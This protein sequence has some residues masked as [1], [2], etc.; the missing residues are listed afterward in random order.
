MILRIRTTAVA[1]LILYTLLAHIHAQAATVG[2]D[3]TIAQQE[4]NI[5]GK[6]ARGMTING[7][8]PGPTLQFKEGDFARIRVHKWFTSISPSSFNGTPITAWAEA[9]RFGSETRIKG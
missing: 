5:T 1:G 9:C 4:V 3:L 8:I 6:P 2:Y 7:G